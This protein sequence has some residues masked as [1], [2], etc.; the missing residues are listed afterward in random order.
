MRYK[1]YTMSEIDS[2]ANNFIAKNQ[3]I[4][5]DDYVFYFDDKK[6]CYV[7]D[8]R[9]YSL[10]KWMIKNKLY[11][12][13][14]VGEIY[15]VVIWKLCENFDEKQVYITDDKKMYYCNI[16]I[17]LGLLKDY[18]RAYFNQ[19]INKWFLTHTHTNERK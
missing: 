5:F 13:Y 2:I 19:Y 8:Y 3:V 11:G 15:K 6:N 9:K 16:P 12:E 4:A 1:N 10:T 14:P 18:K 17:E 7:P